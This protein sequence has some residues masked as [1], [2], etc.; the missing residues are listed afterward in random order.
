M[1]H[2]GG[3][4]LGRM[5]GRTLLDDGNEHVAVIG[6]TRS[7]KDA[8]II[9]PTMLDSWH[10]STLAH[11]PKGEL[12]SKVSKF[13]SRFSHQLMFDPTDHESVGINVFDWIKDD[14]SMV[15][16][17]QNAIQTLT[18]VDKADH[19]VLGAREYMTAGSIHLL[20]A[21]PDKDKNL[22]GLR[23]FVASGDRGCIEMLGTAA[24]PI[25][26]RVAE[27]MMSVGKKGSDQQE[28]GQSAYRGS[29][30]N[31]A[32]VL[33]ALW[34][35]PLVDR[36]TSRSD[37]ALDDLVCAGS[38]ADLWLVNRPSDSERINP[39]LKVI[40]VMVR[41][42]LMR[43]ELLV[44]GR[45][46]E[47]WLMMLLNEFLEFKV[48]D[49]VNS[50]RSAASYFIKYLLAAQ[51]LHSVEAEHGSGLLNNCGIRVF[52]R[53]NDDREAQRISGMIGND[54]RMVAHETRTYRREAFLAGSRSISPRE[55]VRPVLPPDELLRW[56]P[57]RHAIVLGRGKPIKA[58]VRMAHEDRRL[59]GRIAPPPDLRAAGGAYA[60]LPGLFTSPWLGKR[61]EPPR[62][63]E[64]PMK[65]AKEAK[66][67]PQ[68]A[69]LEAPKEAVAI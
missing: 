48:K 40:M 26:V 65:T 17:V 50:M 53:P 39:L 25:C 18:E 67:K 29:I 30:Y 5:G 52:F 6:P 19:W 35:D 54:R 46:K 11:D 41:R 12:W 62:Q 27:Q 45:A 63:I 7:G 3:V 10:G 36:I 1:R 4:I 60:D 16:Q 61:I 51:D 15:S 59:S 2:P 28:G 43:D 44:R 13:R 8:S 55:E 22:G 31:S 9:I 49:T 33:L 20:R 42:A 68:P 69:A 34:D 58:E 47:H 37:F 38:P 23:R 32:G 57:R 66:G 56:E 21:A 14:G 64:A 24:D